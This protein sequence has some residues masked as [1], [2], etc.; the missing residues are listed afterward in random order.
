M[1]SRID[2]GVSIEIFKVHA[3]LNMK[4]T[5][6]AFF[7]YILLKGTLYHEEWY[8]FHFSAIICVGI[9]TSGAFFCP[10]LYIPGFLGTWGID[11]LFIIFNL[12]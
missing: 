12:C 11:T 9:T 8:Q 5:P 1:S 2:L 10:R 7:F 4:T 3:F 6:Q